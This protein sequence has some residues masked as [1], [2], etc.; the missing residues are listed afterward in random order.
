METCYIVLLL[1]LDYMAPIGVH[2]VE[3]FLP[4]RLQHGYV[5]LSFH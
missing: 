4:M 1:F 2:W 5:D 3:F